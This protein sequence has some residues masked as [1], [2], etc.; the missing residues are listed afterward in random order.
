M[1]ET[2]IYLIRGQKVMVDS[3]LAELYGVLTR[4]L[5]KAVQRNHER[6]PA[7]FM[8]RLTNE[9]AKILMFQIGTS[10]GG[11]GGRRKLPLAFTEQGVAMLSGVLKSDRAIQVNVAIMRTFVKIRHMLTTH[12]DLAEKLEK[13]EQT[14]DA[15]FK[16]VFDAIRLLMQDKVSEERNPKQPIGF[17]P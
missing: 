11:W 12:K 4:N 9:E 7:D 16:V 10:S 13:L 17:E 14:Y 8:F 6:F 1:I 2:R 15:K 3:D 5:N